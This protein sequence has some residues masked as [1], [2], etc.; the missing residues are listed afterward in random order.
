VPQAIPVFEIVPL[1]ENVAQPAAPPADE[2]MRFE[3][4]ARPAVRIL[5]E[6]KVALRLVVLAVPK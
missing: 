4:D 3:V 2:T 5:V 1:I 6:A